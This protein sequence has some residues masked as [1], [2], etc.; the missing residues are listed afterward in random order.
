MHGRRSIVCDS[1]GEFAPKR[2]TVCM[3]NCTCFTAA[4]YMG[5][6]L[7]S[8]STTVKSR[9]ELLAG[10]DAA[11]AVHRDNFLC[12]CLLDACPLATCRPWNH[13]PIGKHYTNGIVLPTHDNFIT[14]Y[15]LDLARVGRSFTVACLNCLSGFGRH[16][17]LRR[18][19]TD[20]RGSSKTLPA[21]PSPALESA[22]SNQL[23][24]CTG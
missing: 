6:K 8:F 17:V 14:C 7:K 21:L 20:H 19:I 3:A 24:Q 10:A 1:T 22:A 12:F 15:T 9:E 18:D 2:P 16:K 11:V 4:A 13:G 23:R 5:G